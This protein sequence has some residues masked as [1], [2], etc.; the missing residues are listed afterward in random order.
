MVYT[1]KLDE[2]QGICTPLVMALLKGQTECA[3]ILRSYGA[4]E[5]K[6]ECVRVRQ[7][8]ENPVH[9]AIRQNLVEGR[10]RLWNERPMVESLSI[11][12][13]LRRSGIYTHC[14]KI[15]ALGIAVAVRNVSTMKYLIEEK[16]ALINS[17][18]PDVIPPIFC[19]ELSFFV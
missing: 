14:N 17:Y 4:D 11:L 18:D 16:K 3:A 15:S 19:S 12:D 10:V 13:E 5:S 6:A 1:G 7:I 8:S 2:G 9:N